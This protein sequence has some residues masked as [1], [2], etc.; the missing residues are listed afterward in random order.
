MEKKTKAC[1]YCWEEILE[2]AKKC[3]HCGEFL[4]GEK[5]VTEK[6]TGKKIFYGILY[7]LAVLFAFFILMLLRPVKEEP[8]KKLSVDKPE[9]IVSVDQVDIDNCMQWIKD[10]TWYE[11]VRVK[12][13]KWEK[14]TTSLNEHF[15]SIEWTYIEAVWWWN[16]N[17]RKF[18]CYKDLD[19]ELGKS[20]S[21]LFVLEIDWNIIAED[22]D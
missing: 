8:V 3:K 1:P 7:V 19:W 21:G 14:H 11:H 6:K 17:V 12:S 9:N 10:K 16:E 15:L 5:E 13:V 18:A 2:V 22:M 4:E 20:H